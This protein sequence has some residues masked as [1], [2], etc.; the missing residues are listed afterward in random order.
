ISPRRGYHRLSPLLS[1][2]MNPVDCAYQ[3]ADAA[4]QSPNGAK[5]FSLLVIE[6]RSY[7]QCSAVPVHCSAARGP[8][9]FTR[10]YIRYLYR[11]ASSCSVRPI[12]S[13]MAATW[14]M[15]A[16]KGVVVRR[17]TWERFCWQRSIVRF[18]GRD[19]YSRVSPPETTG[20]ESFG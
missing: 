7:E 2:R 14:Q 10:A 3:C 12:R 17:P 16:T 18:P 6:W 15:V 13:L 19:F 8:L 4:F 1:A 11:G 9:P 20:M 5:S